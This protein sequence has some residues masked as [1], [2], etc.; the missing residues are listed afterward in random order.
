MNIGKLK[1]AVASY[2]GKAASTFIVG[3]G[4]YQPD[5]LLTAL[6]NASKK[7]S[8]VSQLLGVPSLWPD[9]S[10]SNDRRQFR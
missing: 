4:S 1:E 5:L 8:T 7:S 9:F 2:L 3:S 6:N 10:C